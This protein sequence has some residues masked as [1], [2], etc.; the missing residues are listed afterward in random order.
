MQIEYI[1]DISYVHENVDLNNLVNSIVKNYSD[2][3]WYASDY[4]TRSHDNK[5]TYNNGFTCKSLENLWKVCNDVVNSKELY[6]DFIN[7][8]E[9]D[10]TV[11][12]ESDNNS[13]DDYE[14]I[15]EFCKNKNNDSSEI[16]TESDMTNSFS[17]S[18]SENS[19]S[20]NSKYSDLSNDGSIQIYVSKYRL[21]ELGEN[22]KQK[23]EM[24]KLNLKDSEKELNE[25]LSLKNNDK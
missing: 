14:S 1:F 2:V 20:D 23:Y 3:K 11:L 19:D 25:F 7:K 5:S 15:K 8:E 17:S 6:I 18:E 10:N 22:Y 21:N 9:Y 13:D 24:S 16:N 4:G 12:S